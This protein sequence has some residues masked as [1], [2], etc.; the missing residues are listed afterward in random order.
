MNILILNAG[1][2]TLKFALFDASARTELASGVIDWQGAA[3][4]NCAFHAPGIVATRC[5]TPVTDYGEAVTWI[6]A[7]LDEHVTPARI[8]LVGHRIVH[9]G[10]KFTEPTLIDDQ[11]TAA[12]ERISELAPLH[13]PPALTA[14]AAARLALPDAGHVAVFDTAFFASLP[15][16]AVVYPIPFQWF[17]QFGIRRFGFHGISHSYCASRA[18][19]LLQRQGFVHKRLVICH[20]GNG[21]SATA[22]LSGQP[23]ATTMGFTPLDGLMMGTRSG[24]VDPGILLH[25]VQQHGLPVKQLEDSLNRQS[26]LLGVSGVSSD[27]RVVA[28]AAE[29][30]NPRARLAVDMFADRIRATIGALAVTLGGVDGLIFTA[31]I[32]A[33]S[34]ALRSR[35]CDGLQCLHLELDEEKNLRNAPDSDVACMGS[36]GRIVLIRT[37]EELAIAQACARLFNRSRPPDTAEHDS[38]NRDVIAHQGDSA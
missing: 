9:G 30:G 12:L 8:G 31:G 22:V 27:F 15:L 29:T 23:I 34:A 24:A 2:S 18:A 37:R 19:E 10:T 5:N 33:N 7:R 26:G 3:A 16:R 38:Q 6:L 17:E 21:C 11:V 35:V 36:G 20:L 32:G 13:N 1:S 25:L 14:I 4:A 28:S